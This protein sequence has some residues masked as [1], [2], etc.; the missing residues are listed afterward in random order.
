MSSYF[1]T[2]RQSSQCILVPKSESVF[3]ESVQ[4]ICN[5]LII[6]YNS[7][8]QLVLCLLQGSPR[9]RVPDRY[10]VRNFFLPGNVSL[11]VACKKPNSFITN[12]PKT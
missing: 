5:F 6:L 10:R 11:Q 7:F 2:I 9:L 3:K 8:F 12:H 1:L 4:C